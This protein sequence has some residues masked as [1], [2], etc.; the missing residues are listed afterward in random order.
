[1]QHLF[2]TIQV[3]HSRPRCCRNSCDDV[4]VDLEHRDARGNFQ[5]NNARFP[6]HADIGS[7]EIVAFSSSNTAERISK[8]FARAIIQR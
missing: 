4:G 8:A 2:Q 3:P 6:G 5:N 1:M 7:Y